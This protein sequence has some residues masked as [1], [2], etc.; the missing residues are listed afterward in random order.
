MSATPNL[1]LELVPSNSLQPWVAVN[2]ALQ[3][4]D[5]LIQLNV[6]DKDLTA[7]PATVAGDVGKRWIVPAGA[8]DAWAGHSTDI[9]LCIGAGQWRFIDAREGFNAWVADEAKRY[10]FTAGA[11]VMV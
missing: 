9:A 3:L 7:P 4:I 10:N 2:D 1:G 8:T 11:W 5:A 6:L